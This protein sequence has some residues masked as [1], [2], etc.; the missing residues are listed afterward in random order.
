MALS[1]EERTIMEDLI[2]QG[3]SRGEVAGYIGSLRR[4]VSEEPEEPEMAQPQQAQQPKKTGIIGDIPSDIKETGTAL[5][6][7]GGKFKQ[8]ISRIKENVRTGETGKIEAIGQGIGSGAMAA[9]RAVGDIF[10]GGAKLFASPETE[11]GTKEFIGGVAKQTAKDPIISRLTKNISELATQIE[12]KDPNTYE[13]LRAIL[14]TGALAA[15]VAGITPAKKVGAIAREGVET[16]AEVATKA[17]VKTKSGLGKITPTIKRV[18][19]ETLKQRVVGE[20]TDAYEKSFIGNNKT[21]LNRLEKVANKSSYGDKRF[22]VRELFGELADEGYMPVRKGELADMNPIIDDLGTRQKKIFT[23]LIPILD[24]V[25]KNKMKITALRKTILAKIQADGRFS[26][27]FERATREAERALNSLENKYGKEIKLSQLQ[28]AKVQAAKKSKAFKTEVFEQDV[29]N[30]I[31]RTFRDAIDERVPGGLYKEANDRWGKLQRMINTAEAIDNQKIDIGALGSKV[32]QLGGALA[33]G[34]FLFPV[35]GPGS[36][37]VAGIS[38]TYGG[39]Q[40][41]KYLRYMR[42]N[43]KKFNRIISEIKGDQDLIEKLMKTATGEDKA[44]LQDTLKQT[45]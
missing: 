15:D 5:K 43:P 27:D 7:T 14:G 36:L 42:F 44:F 10:M 21:T 29:N 11:K 18:P 24:K 16:G 4:G 39:N 6:E 12:D 45:H 38:A 28:N 23:E 9:S 37:V 40:V 22:T 1:T 34:G 41:A 32:G 35:T 26:L 19:E 30:I 33:V 8:D 17:G 3:R 25:P 2:R 31:D 13:S 20:L